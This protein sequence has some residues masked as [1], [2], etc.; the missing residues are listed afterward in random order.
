MRTLILIVVSIIVKGSIPHL[1]QKSV[2][3]YELPPH[4]LLGAHVVSLVRQQD[5]FE[6][7]CGSNRVIY[8]NFILLYAAFRVS[9]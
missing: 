4:L 2:R 5:L 3:L 1:H 8:S 6:I 9:G 7:D